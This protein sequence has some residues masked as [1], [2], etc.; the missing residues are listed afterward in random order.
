MS[1]DHH[2]GSQSTEDFHMHHDVDSGESRPVYPAN[3]ESQD[4][5]WFKAATIA[6]T[7]CGAIILFVLI[8]AAIRMLRSDGHGMDSA[9]KLGTG[10][11]PSC[12]GRKIILD[13]GDAYNQVYGGSSQ[14]SNIKHVP[15][16]KMDDGLP[17]SYTIYPPPNHHQ[18]QNFQQNPK[19]SSDSK[20]EAQAKKNQIKSLEYTL[21]PQSCHEGHQKP[22]NTDVVTSP[23]YRDVNL[24]P[25]PHGRTHPEIAMDNK[26][27]EKDML[28]AVP[29]NWTNNP[30][31]N[32]YGV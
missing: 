12:N 1:G 28:T 7:V 30:T 5:V 32:P 14:Q 20:N 29:A 2:R 16:L 15:L 24:S 13:F 23:A 11:S 22:I 31:S 18:L 17:P 27:Y 3:G 6:I 10:S 26:T 8:A 4:E 19:V 21:L 9:S 25:T